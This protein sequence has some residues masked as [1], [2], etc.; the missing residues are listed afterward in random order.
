MASLGFQSDLTIYAI[1]R[2]LPSL[3]IFR[4]HTLD[5][6]FLT[7]EIC[8]AIHLLSIFPT[9]SVWQHHQAD[10]QSAEV[11]PSTANQNANSPSRFSV[12]GGLEISHHQHTNHSSLSP[13]PPR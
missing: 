9:D 6:H 8:T 2:V 1:G 7:I 3:A 11:L 4:M 13:M 10:H 5:G 12:F